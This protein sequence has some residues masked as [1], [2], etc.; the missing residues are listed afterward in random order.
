METKEQ[1][2]DRLEKEIKEL[3]KRIID[4]TLR[5]CMTEIRTGVKIPSETI[6]EELSLEQELKELEKG[7]GKIR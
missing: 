6:K 4:I 3:K 5:L 2:I 7:N 1:K